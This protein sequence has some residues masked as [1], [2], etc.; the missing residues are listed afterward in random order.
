MRQ[1]YTLLLLL[2]ISLAASAQVSDK[3]LYSCNG[4]DKSI[5]ATLSSGKAIIILS[6]GLDCSI[7]KNKAADWQNWAATN[8]NKVE[9]WG[10]MTFTYSNNTPNC[11]QV[12]NWVNSYSWNNIFTFIDSS[13]FYFQSGTPRYIVYSPTDSSI[14]YTGTDETQARNKALSVSTIKI[15]MKEARLENFGYRMRN[16]NLELYNMPRKRVQVRLLNLSGQVSRSFEINSTHKEVD[17]SGLAPG[18]YLLQLFDGQSSV[19]R[20]LVKP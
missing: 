11:Q 15:G 5:H 14:V 9:V 19:T 1:F 6:K 12:Q 10:A 13:E 7:C 8:L 3:V 20:K 4:T 17:V 16:G 2:L 18:I